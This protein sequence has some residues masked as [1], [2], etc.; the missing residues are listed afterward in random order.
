MS[1]QFTLV[2]WKIT[3]L[4]DN[5]CVQKVVLKDIHNIWLLFN[6][7]FFKRTSVSH[8]YL[9]KAHQVQLPTDVDSLWAD[10]ENPDFLEAPLSIDDARC[11]GC[12][13]RR[14]HR[15]SNDVQRLDYDF[16]YWFLQDTH[17]TSEAHIFHTIFTRL[18]QVTGH[19]FLDFTF[20]Y[21]AVFFV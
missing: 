6:S 3:R 20:K 9:V 18:I 11:H 8:V 5:L 10:G 7:G 19:I 13:Q 21:T 14:G 17:H 1:P 12:R 2:L 4:N 16:L 15:D